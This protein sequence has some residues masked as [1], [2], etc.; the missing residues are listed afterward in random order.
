MDCILPDYRLTKEKYKELW[1]NCI[2]ILDTNVLFNLYR[3]SPK[4]RKGFIDI[5]NG[6]ADR[7]WIPNQVALEYYDNK[8][9]VI[10]GEINKYKIISNIISKCPND[11]KNDIIKR[12]LSRKHTATSEITEELLK[13][14]DESF[15]IIIEDLENILKKY[16][17]IKDFEHIDEMI[18]KLLVGRVGNPYS[19]EVLEEIC[20]EGLKRYQLKL[21]PGYEDEKEKEGFKK[22]GDL[23]LWFQI[24]DMA[25]EKKKPVILICEDLKEDWWWISSE[26]T[27]GPRPELI[28]EFSIKTEM[29]F[30][31]LNSAI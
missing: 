7:L 4:L 18:G 9:T 5:L 15:K 26:G 23:I 6:I 8:S 12:D 20:N 17:K 31:I 22:F 2:F 25:K 29:L 11:I 13:K 14:L 3:Y 27:I 19:V 24:I 1:D 30:Y 10:T 28:Q 16:P 21:P